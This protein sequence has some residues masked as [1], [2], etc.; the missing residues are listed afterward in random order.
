MKQVNAI[1]E[2]NLG[3][4]DRNTLIRKDVPKEIISRFYDKDDNVLFGSTRT[5][6]LVS[7]EY[8]EGK[9]SKDGKP[10]FIGSSILYDG[11][12]NSNCPNPELIKDFNWIKSY[13]EN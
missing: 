10:I 5:K 1:I 7:Y 13:L 6:G 4:W 12:G 2:A 9:F 8:I 11:K 3:K